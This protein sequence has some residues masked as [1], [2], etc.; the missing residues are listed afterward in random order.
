VAYLL[1]NAPSY[2]G[3]IWHADAYRP[4]AGHVLGFMS[5]G[6]VVKKIMTFFKKMRCGDLRSIGATAGSKSIP[7]GWL[8][9]WLAAAARWPATVT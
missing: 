1:L 5:I 4:C 8:A 6:I 9:G 7:A 3:E 2:G